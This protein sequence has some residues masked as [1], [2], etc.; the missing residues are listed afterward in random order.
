MKILLLALAAV[1]LSACAPSRP[2]LE[3]HQWL[4]NPQ[5]SA[6]ARTPNS[7]YWLKVSAISIAT[8]FDGKSLVYRIGEQR[9]EKDFYNIYIS[10]PSE[11]LTNA[12]TQWI[13]DSQVFK[14]TVGQSNTFF[15]Y[16]TLQATVNE[17]YGDYRNQAE[18]VISI[19]YYLTVISVGKTSPLIMAPKYS[20]R[21]PLKDNR[22]ETLVAGLNRGLAE[23]LAQFEQDL[24]QNSKNLPKAIGQ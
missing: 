14:V 6:E 18:A 19:Q 23:I 22:P 3:P 11:M 5:R 15:P 16:Y 20:K 8:P 7:E 21:I 1:F 9:Y 24:Y 4:I 12:T 17:F 10:S 2:S 13:N